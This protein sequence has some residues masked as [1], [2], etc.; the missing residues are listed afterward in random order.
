MAATSCLGRRDD[1]SRSAR[2]KRD[3][4]SH[5][6]GARLAAAA[7]RLADQVWCCWCQARG[8][9]GPTEPATSRLGR[10]NA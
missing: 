2:S 4:M 6:R 3:Q 1:R 8:Y 7:Q 9:K 5:E 10:C